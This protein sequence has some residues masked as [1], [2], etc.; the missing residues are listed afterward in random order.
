MELTVACINI[1]QWQRVEATLVPS[2]EWEFFL[3]LLNACRYL[4]DHPAVVQG[5]RILDVGSG[6]GASAIASAK[7][8]AKSV[9]ANDIDPGIK[10][11]R[12]MIPLVRVTKGIRFAQWFLS[13]PFTSVDPSSNPT[14]NR[15]LACGLGFQSV[16]T[17]L[18]VFS[19]HKTERFFL[20]PI[21]PVIRANC[22]VGCVI[23][24]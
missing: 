1:E 20:F 8:G 4:L 22:A 2:T 15:S 6:C 16:P 24:K 18:H 12:G 17:W 10:C 11:S 23:N 7:C 5:K 19:S 3:F 21:R 14:L 13:L 9:L